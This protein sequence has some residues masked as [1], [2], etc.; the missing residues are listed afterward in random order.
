[1]KRHLSLAVCLVLALARCAAAL[2][3]AAG[4]VDITPDLKTESTWM[5][6]FG[7]T[8]RW[9]EGVHDPLYARIVVLREGKTT[10]AMVGLDLLGFYRNDVERLRRLAGYD[11]PGRSLFL[12]STHTH[13]GPDTLGLWGPMIGISGINPRYHARI[14]GRI[15]EA[16]KLL[17]SQL[18]PATAAGGR[19]LLDPRG[20]CRDSRDPQIIDPNLATLRLTGLDGK[21]IATVVNWSCHAEVLGRENRLITADYPGPLCM[22]VEEKTGGACLFLNGVIGGLLTP[23]SRAENF[24]ESYRIGTTVADAALALKTAS[25]PRRPLSYRSELVRVPVEN[26]RYR[27][28]L[29]ALTYGHDLYDSAGRLLPRYKR[30]TLSL[31]ALLLGL[32]ADNE[33]WVETEV[34]VLDVGPARLL[35]IPGELFP[36]LAIGG[37][38][39]KYTFGRPIITPG[40]PD[41]PD[42]AKAPKGPYLR[43]LIKAPAPMVVGL[44]NDELGYIMPGYDFKIRPSRFMLPRLPGHYE[45]T[46][47]VGRSVTNIVVDAATRLLKEK[48]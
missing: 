28:F 15:A 7:A 30:W 5:A 34:S 12:N 42:L 23:D 35:G 22:R 39:G 3:A 36:E 44:A 38:D 18:R 16:L 24:Y 1:M 6:G 48:K 20:L 46:N 25:S 17:E 11:V 40:N 47:S 9:P 29:F 8:G 4:K 45:E 26:S 10:V 37:Y 33:P 32:N 13:S 41:P 2:E 21:P 43:D 14:L 19:G 27:M 31:R